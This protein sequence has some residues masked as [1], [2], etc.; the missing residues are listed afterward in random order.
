M[1]TVSIRGRFAE[2]LRDPPVPSAGL[3]LVYTLAVLYIVPLVVPLLDIVFWVLLT[4]VTDPQH[5]RPQFEFVTFAIPILT[6]TGLVGVWMSWYR[7][8]GWATLVY[9]ALPVVAGVLAYF[10]SDRCLQI[11]CPPGRS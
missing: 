11:M 4:G 3:L 1:V 10:Y 9:A 7:E 8:R 5:K 6:L 2:W